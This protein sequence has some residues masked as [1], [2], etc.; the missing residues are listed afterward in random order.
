MSGETFRKP[1][2]DSKKPRHEKNLPTVVGANGTSLGAISKIN[3]EIV[4]G[5]KKLQTNLPSM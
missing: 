1:N 4:I 3:S 2:L 5:K